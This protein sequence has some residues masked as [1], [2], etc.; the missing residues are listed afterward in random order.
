MIILMISEYNLIEMKKFIIILSLSLSVLSVFT[1]K[2]MTVRNSDTGE[3]FEISVPYGFRIY[4][5]NSNWLDS[6][7]Y[8][9]ER[10]RYGEPW[11]YEALGDCYRY[12]KGGVGQSILKALVYYVMSGMDIEEM[13]K[14]SVKESPRDHMSLIYKL[15]ARWED[16]DEK[17]MR[18]VIDI[19]NEEGYH[20]ADVLKSFMGYTTPENII[21][22]VEHSIMS[23]EISPDEMLFAVMRY[24][25][26]EA[27]DLCEDK[28][29]LLIAACEKFPYIYDRVGMEILDGPLNIYPKDDEKI[30]L[31]AISFLSEADKSAFLS[32]Q[33]AAIL[34]RHYK[35]EIEAGR[36][37]A[38]EVEMER[39]AALAELPES[40]ILVFPDK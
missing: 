12:G 29:D 16:K 31:K 21:S 39:L 5:Y 36:M 8:L 15:V 11:A 6:V 9:V 32:R 18:D 23:P 28:E 26:F 38:D 37:A 35:S 27:W 33:G 40:E 4:E 1:D 30:R 25:I 3:S 19:L 14:N 20:D 7:P 10:A 22:L 13:A 17:G 24:G 2:K 34:Y